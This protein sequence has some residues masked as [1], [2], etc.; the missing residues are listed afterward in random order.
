MEQQLHKISC[1]VTLSYRETELP[2]GDNLQKHELQN[3]IKTLR[4]KGLNIRYFAVGEYGGEKGRS[5]YHLAIF[6]TDM[7]SIFGTSKIRPADKGYATHNDKHWKKGRVHIAALTSKSASYICG[8]TVKKLTDT[9]NLIV[10][11]RKPE[12]TLQSRK[13]PLGTKFIETACRQVLLASQYHDEPELEAIKLFENG[14]VRINQ[15]MWPLD[16][17]MLKTVYKT[18]GP[19]GDGPNQKKIRAE[20][21]NITD[22]WTGQNIIKARKAESASDHLERHQ[23]R[24]S[25]GKHF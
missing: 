3:Y 16:R 25:S 18:L 10:N 9:H 2:P 17:Q 12:F 4:N 15:K 20:L 6:G 1:F 8:Y 19:S 21:R 24:V 23:K 5:H 11:G 13:P 22:R 7:Y 14:N